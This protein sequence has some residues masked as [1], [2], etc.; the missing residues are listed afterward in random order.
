MG[1]MS[2]DVKVDEGLKKYAET[3][4]VPDG[5]LTRNGGV[6]VRIR[7]AGGQE[8]PEYVDREDTGH[9]DGRVFATSEQVDRMLQDPDVIG[10]EVERASLMF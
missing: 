6:S 2:G 9:V 4:R 1:G 5:A 7:Y 3:G 10:L 8:L